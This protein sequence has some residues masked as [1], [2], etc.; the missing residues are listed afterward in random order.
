MPALSHLFGVHPWD[1]G[2]PRE[3]SWDELEHYMDA[4]AEHNREIKKAEKATRQRR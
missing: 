1:I 4:L 3:L 2:G